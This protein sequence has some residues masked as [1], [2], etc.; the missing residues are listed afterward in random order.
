M[1]QVHVDLAVDPA[2]EQEMLQYFQTVFRP[3]AVKFR[4][5]VDVRMLKL[6]AV[7]AGTA[8]T[9][10]NYRFAITYETEELR[11]KWVASEVHQDVWGGMEKTL[12]SPNYRVLLFDVNA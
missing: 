4:G 2:K 8:P 1:V 5:Y 10:M 6:R 7:P 9:G 3:A 12:S 11:Q